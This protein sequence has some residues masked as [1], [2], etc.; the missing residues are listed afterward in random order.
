MKDLLAKFQAWF[1]RSPAPRNDV[2][3]AGNPQ[4]VDGEAKRLCDEGAQFLN[5][6][7]LADALPVLQQAIE[8]A[9]EFA[10]AHFFL[11]VAQKRLGKMEDARDSLLL[12][13]CF[14]PSFPEAFFYLGVCAASDAVE[15][16]NYFRKAVDADADHANAH[17][18][19]GTLFVKRKAFDEAERAFRDAIRSDRN[20]VLAHSNLGC[21]LITELDRV[22][23]GVGLLRSAYHLAPDNE[24]VQRNWTMGLLHG[25]ELEKAIELCDHLLEQ[26]PN[27]HKVRFNRAL[28]WLKLGKFGTGWNDYEARKNIDSNGIRQLGGLPDWQGES[29]GDRTIL[30]C[31]E[32]GLG[33]QIMFASCIPYLAASAEKC[34]VECEPRLEKLFRRSFPGAIVT[35]T[36]CTL[37]SLASQGLTHVDYQLAMGSLPRYCRT[38]A[39]EFPRHTG[40][41]SADPGR[42]AFW[43][44]RLDAMSG[45]M[46][47]AISWQG[48]TRTSRSSTRSLPLDKLLPVL[49]CQSADFISLQYTD[50]A[51]ELASLEQKH[52]V[53]VHHWSEAVGDYDETAAIVTAVDLVISV[54]TSLVHLAGA[55]DKAVWVLAPAVAEWRYGQS[56]EAMVWYPSARLFRQPAPGDWRSVVEHVAAELEKVSEAPGARSRLGEAAVAKSAIPP[57]AP[58]KRAGAAAV[59]QNEPDLA[60]PQGPVS[61]QI[62]LNKNRV[63][64]AIETRL[65]SSR[66]LPLQPVTGEPCVTLLE[67]VIVDTSIW[68]VIHGNSI[69]WR[70][71]Y[72]RSLP[73]SPFIAG[74]TDDQNFSV[75]DMPLPLRHIEDA[76]VLIG[77]DE[78]YSHWLARSLLKLSLIENDARFSALPRLVHDQL[79]RSQMEYVNLLALD[80]RQF[81]HVPRPALVSCRELAVPVLLR[82]HPAMMQGI[83]WLRGRLQSLMHA[84]GAFGERLYVSRGGSPRRSVINESE[85]IHELE[86]FQ[87]RVIEP[88]SMTVRDQIGAFSAAKIIVAPHGAG[89][90]NIIFAPPGCAVVELSSTLIQHMTD[91][92]FIAAQLGQRYTKLVSDDYGELLSGHQKLHS[93]FSVNVREIIGLIKQ[94]T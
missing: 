42:V 82:N 63:Q 45:R 17:N 86:A 73:N 87:F 23:E 68:A 35:R 31:A 46:K 22:D 20:H 81:I 85:L 8:R 21:L 75:I 29:L 47:I 38:E 15:A 79:G 62:R 27:L 94:L 83:S 30:L 88:G 28:A 50:C 32:Q 36:P 77:S 49:S 33:D 12:A 24:E 64:G 11:G 25:G 41:L 39:A 71:V 16:E 59:P 6:N 72:G 40:Y 74:T 65:V 76:C 7:R 70:D 10:D 78:N 67:R 61:L 14:K 58:G 3:I 9:P 1:A 80:E 90:T 60:N 5:A 18:A 37:A 2:A 91:F 48:G 44:K 54:T 57:S 66:S 84:G 92:Q 19:L 89:L 53:K 51:G 4:A 34:A 56:G 93:D 13:T 55:L 52:G 26:Q 69:Y 43:R